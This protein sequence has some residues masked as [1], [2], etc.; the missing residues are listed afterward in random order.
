[1][2]AHDQELPP[3]EAHDDRAAIAPATHDT[4]VHVR[5]MMM[6]MRPGHDLGAIFA[7][8]REL[9][10]EAVPASSVAEAERLMAARPLPG[11]DEKTGQDAAA[12][13]PFATALRE[14]IVAGGRAQLAASPGKLRRRRTSLVVGFVA[15]AAALLVLYVVGPEFAELRRGAGGGVEASAVGERSHGHGAAP[16]LAPPRPPASPVWKDTRVIEAPPAEPEPVVAPVI[17]AVIESAP[18]PVPED[19][20]PAAPSER[21]RRAKS[22]STVT[23]EQ[24]AQALWQAGELAAAEKKFR[25]IVRASGRTQRAEFAYGDL[26][27]LARQLRGTAGQVAMWREYLAV[28]PHGQ[29]ADDAHA[30]LCLRGPEAARE[31]CWRDYV[32]RHPQ[33]AYRAQAE[34]ALAQARAGQGDP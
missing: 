14:E 18:T 25:E 9:D 24:E 13:G 7:R 10:P 2:A 32:E 30:G 20:K 17:E 15:A 4:S 12:L 5:R 16:L 6:K 34:A 1:M 3:S 33:G 22:A 28:F 31:A 26:F 19:S 11:G 23:L 8:A 21:P 27:A 29:F